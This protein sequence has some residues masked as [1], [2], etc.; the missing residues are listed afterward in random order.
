MEVRR[1]HKC[2]STFEIGFRIEGKFYPKAVRSDE[3]F[4]QLYG[5]S[6]YAHARKLRPDRT[7]RFSHRVEK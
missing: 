1:H 4:E 3:E 2:G 5:P 7:L 6:A